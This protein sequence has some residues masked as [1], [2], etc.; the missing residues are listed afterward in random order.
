MIPTILVPVILGLVLLFAIGLVFARLY[1]RASK[2]MA[3][4]RTGL[5]GS[6]VILDGG[7]L[8]LPVFH[9]ITAV[10]LKTL[11]LVVRRAE[12]EALITNDKLRA[13]V[14]VEFF[15]RVKRDSDAIQMAA[16]SLGTRTNDT[17]ALKELVEGKFVD[18]LRAVAAQMTL[19]DLHLKR[20]DFVQSVQNV[21]AEDL[22]KNGLEL[23]SASLTGLDQTDQKF[24]NPENAFDAEGLTKLKEK[25]EIK[26]RER[27]VIEQDTEVAIKRK[28]LE[29]TRE[30]LSLEQSSEDATLAQEREIAFMRAAAKMEIAKREADSDQ[31][32]EN[33]RIEALRKVETVKIA[34]D[35]DLEIERQKSQ[36]DIA[37]QS[38]ARVAAEAS[39]E[40]ARITADQ[41]VQTVKIETEKTVAITRQQSEIAIAEQSKAR[42]AAEA[43][44]ALARAEEVRADERVESARA[45]EQAER[46]KAVELTEARKE[47][48]KE[49]LKVTVG[50]E[51]DRTAAD[52]RAEALRIEAQASADAERIRADARA[53]S[54][55]VDS[56]GQRALNEARNSL[57]EKMVE[58]ELRLRIVEALPAIVAQ[59]VKPIEK[60]DSIRI[61]DMG[62]LGKA[63]E[64]AESNGEAGDNLA[65]KAVAAALR[66]RTQ[67]PLLDRLLGE[68]GLGKGLDGLVPE[69]GRKAE[70]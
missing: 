20:A 49:A 54:Y 7:A 65:D 11:K 69:I 34:K 37:K 33:A 4:V 53:R 6:K 52:E 15:V 62:G 13:D 70:E 21:V 38:E 3:F 35:R 36:I 1:R 9:E 51:A 31:L 27:F 44:A 19:E 18:A 57:S 14:T 40:Q 8:V 23:E 24:F 39:A 64:G 17:M 45:I 48:E 66:Y 46:R 63:T 58:L 67:A 30:K 43:A 32:S 47:A 68:L 25:T 61:V 5:G 2:E 26:R 12:N 29:A 28:N 16:Q 50:A 22:S 55:E 56:A 41:Q 42:S 10:N 59:M 60:I